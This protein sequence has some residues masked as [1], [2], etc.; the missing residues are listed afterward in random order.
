MYDCSLLMYI[1]I[2]VVDILS[3]ML[4]EWVYIFPYVF[5]HYIPELKIMAPA[6]FVANKVSSF[7]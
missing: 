3:L 1:D 6:R 2:L 4:V 5:R 7:V